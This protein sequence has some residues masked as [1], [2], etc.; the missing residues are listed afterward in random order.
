MFIS[1]KR[2]RFVQ[3]IRKWSLVIFFLDDANTTNHNAAIIISFATD[4]S[5]NVGQ[6]VMY[7]EPTALG[8]STQLLFHKAQLC[9]SYKIRSLNCSLIANYSEPFNKSDRGAENWQSTLIVSRNNCSHEDSKRG[10]Q[11]LNVTFAW[12]LISRTRALRTK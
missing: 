5:G 7:R 6:I 11:L 1:W 10:T 9:R 2:Q 4:R 8:V 3:P 12:K